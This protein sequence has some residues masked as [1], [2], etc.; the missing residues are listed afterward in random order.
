MKAR[1]AVKVRVLGAHTAQLDGPGVLAAF[2]VTSTPYMRA[3]FGGGWQCP[4]DRLDD[5]MAA[6]ELRGY[7]VEPTL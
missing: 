5:V 4:A 7:R 1:S 6:L 2:T 3:R